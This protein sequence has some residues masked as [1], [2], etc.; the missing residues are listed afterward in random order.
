MSELKLLLT[1]IEKLKYNKLNSQH[2]VLKI[3]KYTI[4]RLAKLAFFRCVNKFK[5]VYNSF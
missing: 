1:I 3:L 2:D 4:F 5:L